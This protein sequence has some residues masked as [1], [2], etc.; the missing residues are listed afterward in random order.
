MFS[1]CLTQPNSV[2]LALPELASVTCLTSMVS[3]EKWGKEKKFNF[4][5]GV[6]SMF[7]GAWWTTAWQAPATAATASALPSEMAMDTTVPA[8]ATA[9]AAPAPALAT[10]FTLPLPPVPSVLHRPSVDAS[11]RTSSGSVRARTDSAPSDAPTY[12]LSGSPE[13]GVYVSSPGVRTSL[14]LAASARGH[15]L[16]GIGPPGAMDVAASPSRATATSSLPASFVSS[17]AAAAAVAAAVS[18]LPVTVLLPRRYQR[19][20]PSQLPLPLPRLQP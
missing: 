15:E 12:L 16:V 13:T 17:T 18:A 9:A 8:Q 20:S 6:W 5:W 14:L 3:G 7:L 4:S 19:F 10:V 1:L 11:A 2:S